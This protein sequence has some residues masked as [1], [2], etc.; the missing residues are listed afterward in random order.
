[1]N[2]LDIVNDDDEQLALL[3]ARYSDALEAGGDADPATDPALSAEMRQRLQ[4]ALKC[5]RRLRQS[6][7]RPERPDAITQVMEKGITLLDDI[8]VRQVGRFHILRTL[9]Q[10][11]GGIVFLAFDPDLRREVALKVPHLAVMITPDMRRRFLREARTA[12]CLDHPNL[13][14]VHEAGE[15]HGVC[16]LVSAYCRGGSLAQWLAARTTP[17]PV[18]LA[19]EWLAVL[20]DAV[21]YVHAHGIYHRDIKPGNILL[22]PRSDPPSGEQMFV[23]RL[24]DF[25]LAKLREAQTESTRSGVVMGTLS[26]MAPEQVEGRVRDIGPATDVYGLGA[27]LYE[28]LAG[29][30]P[31]R[32]AT[33]ADTL[34]QVLT[35]EPVPLRRV[36]RDVALDLE[37]VCLK[38]LEK[39]PVRRYASAA[40]LASDLRCFLSGEPIQAR[41]VGRI[42]RLGK[43]V[44]RR[45][46]KTILFA[47]GVLLML[48]VVG[49]ALLLASR[50]QAHDAYRETAG[51][52]S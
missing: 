42:E 44:R 20:A 2:P 32:G 39:E 28:V 40:D 36:R 29:R 5:L 45:P 15:S 17:V 18:R 11:G 30:P 37:T 49:S 16:F 34:S 25:G 43:W 12:A 1:M 48:V 22:D 38:C 14:P 51:K 27:V 33:D 10:G 52:Q 4:W 6:R 13:V 47:L 24:T 8:V 9:G 3:L 35:E 21:Q 26:Y 7:P 50:E 41:P 23:P 19:A 31:F 46:A